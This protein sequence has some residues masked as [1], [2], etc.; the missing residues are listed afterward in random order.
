[1]VETINDEEHQP[2]QEENR[3]ENPEENPEEGTGKETI[4]TAM[5]QALIQTIN[6]DRKD[7]GK[8]T[9]PS[10]Q[11]LQGCIRLFEPGLNSKSKFKSASKSESESK[12]A[13]PLYPTVAPL[14]D[15][16]FA[17]LVQTTEAY[18]EDK[19]T[20]WM[21][22]SPV[23]VYCQLMEASVVDET[24]LCEEI[25][26]AE[27]ASKVVNVMKHIFATRL[28]V[29]LQSRMMTE[30]NVVEGLSEEDVDTVKNLLRRLED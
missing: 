15:S 14:W 25:L 8:G 10:R 21:T 27:A 12:S 20:S 18:Y 19:T 16:I 4:A 23:A 13:A 24:A 1:L 2:E 3:Q 11:T 9:T 30:E 26:P 29:E 22:E 5:I 7:K 28:G 6:L 17:A